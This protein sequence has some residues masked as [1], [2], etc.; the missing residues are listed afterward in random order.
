MEFLYKGATT[1]AFNEKDEAIE[2]LPKNLEELKEKENDLVR[3]A[4][5]FLTDLV[6]EKYKMKA[7]ALLAAFSLFAVTSSA[8][9]EGNARAE[10]KLL[11]EDM[12]ENTLQTSK[13]DEF[14]PFNWKSIVDKITISVGGK[15]EEISGPTGEAIENL[16][17][18]ELVKT[19]LYKDLSAVE[20][21]E[22]GVI[23][24]DAI[25]RTEDA[26]GYFE[27]LKN[28]KENLDDRQII[29]LAQ[30]LGGL[31]DETYNY[32][33]LERGERVEVSDDTILQALKEGGAA[34]ICG[35]L[36]TFEMKTLKALGMDA[37]LQ[38]GSVGG[39]NDVFTGVVADLNGKK[40]IVYVTFWG[41]AVPTGTLNI[42]KAGGIFERAEKSIATFG[43][44]VGNEYE[45][46]FPVETTAQKEIKKASGFEKTEE[47]LAENLEQGKIHKENGLE[48]HISPE[49]KEIKLSKDS[50]VLSYYNYQ[51]INNNPYQ[52]LD[53]LNAL[54]LALRYKGENF[55]V[56]AGVTTVFMNINDLYGN[57]VSQND[58]M[59]RVVMEA[60]DSY[61]LTKGDFGRTALTIG[62]TLQAGIRLPMDR[63]IEFLTMGGMTEAA[64]GARLMFYDT[65][66]NKFYIGADVLGRA[67]I[68]DFQDQELAIKDVLKKL[69]I[70]STV[71]VYEATVDLKAVGGLAD[72]GTSLE[73]SGAVETKE[74]ITLGATYETEKS[75]YEILKS[76]SEKIGVEA[77][78]KG[79]KWGFTISAAQ[80]VEQYGDAEKEKSYDIEAK[81]NILA[82]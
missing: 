18:R 4:G 5:G 49:M 80:T 60:V 65:K 21:Y 39:G 55:G 40:Q 70:G 77:G 16:G 37:F 74:G 48:I 42:E 47:T 22:V 64:L 23:L 68:S 13:A 35:N 76:S 9:A 24:S 14:Y 66:D 3:H 46:L 43:S 31:L 61:E 58:I 1:E 53:D 8:Y 50:I 12:I 62:A 30:R 15:I 81:V 26:K 36:S 17:Y 6:P 56:E 69:A 2:S 25:Y 78:W 51:N 7:T 44:Y 63:G 38:A 79:P 29:L 27:F 72:W 34:G 10:E 19:E 82:F 71:N 20:N 73:L 45:L 67:Q 59:G 52:S 57:K 54:Q 33:M 11:P 41:E 32:D 28:Q 75:A